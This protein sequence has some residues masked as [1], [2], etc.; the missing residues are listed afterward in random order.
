MS[1]KLFLKLKFSD[2]QI[3]ESETEVVQP[4]LT[5]RQTLWWEPPLVFALASEKVMNVMLI[6]GTVVLSSQNVMIGN[7]KLIN[8]S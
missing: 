2:F 8:L 5:E 4:Y 1:N 3:Q 6:I 7:L